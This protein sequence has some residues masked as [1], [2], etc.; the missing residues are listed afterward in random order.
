M[1]T[2][3]LLRAGD[4]WRGQ[5]CYSHTAECDF[6]KPSSLP[7]SF[8]PGADAKV[9][10]RLV[11]TYNGEVKKLFPKYTPTNEIDKQMHGRAFQK[12]AN[13]LS[14]EKRLV[15]SSSVY[16]SSP[17]NFNIQYSVYHSINFCCGFIEFC[18]WSK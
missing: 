17:I 3:K 7:Y 13:K 6:Q 12:H 4:V 2:Q 11:K 1:F 10:N 5:G 9:K 18:S 14:L 8:K 16:R 15:E